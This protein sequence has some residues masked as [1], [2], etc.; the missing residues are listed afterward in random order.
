LL[1]LLKEV[2]Y[3]PPQPATAGFNLRATSTINIYR[4]LKKKKI[5]IKEKKGEN[6]NNRLK[7]FQT[8]HFYLQQLRVIRVDN[9]CI[10]LFRKHNIIIMYRC[11]YLLVGKS[12]VTDLK[13]KIN[14]YYKNIV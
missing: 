7:T 6:K 14:T 13:I 10:P 11:Y 8:L 3:P 4:R 9:N 1:L 2:I 12:F 5:K